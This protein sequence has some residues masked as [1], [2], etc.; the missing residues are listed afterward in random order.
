MSFGRLEGVEELE[1][2][3]VRALQCGEI[4]KAGNDPPEIV[5]SIRFGTGAELTVVNDRG[6]MFTRHLTEGGSMKCP[7]MVNPPLL[8]KQTLTMIWDQITRGTPQCDACGTF[9]T[10]HTEV[11]GWDCQVCG[12]SVCA[13]CIQRRQKDGRVVLTCHNHPD[14]P[15]A[16][17]FVTKAYVDQ[18]I[19]EQGGM[20][21]L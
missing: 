2:R 6:E 20:G 14:L 12:K 5:V 16:N 3:S 18:Q 11:E 10:A 1:W 21:L 17:D 4:L 13:N 9:I 19:K 8:L 15:V 7:V